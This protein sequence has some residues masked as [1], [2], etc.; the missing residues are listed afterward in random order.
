MLYYPFLF[1][2][3][4]LKI[5]NGIPII[6]AMSVIHCPTANEGEANLNSILEA[7][8]GISTARKL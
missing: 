7:P 4:N 1:F 2:P 8:L 6:K 5:I 3:L